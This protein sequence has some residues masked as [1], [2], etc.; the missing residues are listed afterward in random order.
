MLIHQN[1]IG[2]NITVKEIDGNTVVLENELRD[3]TGD[4]CYWA[5]DLL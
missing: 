5:S 1:F 2:G 4:W 3:T